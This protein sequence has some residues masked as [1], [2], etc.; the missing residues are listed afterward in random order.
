[1]KEG[2]Y[3]GLINRLIESKLSELDTNSFHIKQIPI[4][5]TEAA[6]ILS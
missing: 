1:M 3:E 2:L 5:K 4:D 6:K